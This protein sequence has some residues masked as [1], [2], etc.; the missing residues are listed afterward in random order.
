MLFRIASAA[1]LGIDAY[2]VEVEV[3]VSFGLPQFVIVGLP[4]AAVRESKERVQAA[5][6]NCGYEGQPSKIVVN[7]A[8]ANR[9]KEGSS[10]DLPIA[11]GLLAAS[12]HKGLLGPQGTGC[13]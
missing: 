10:F 9:R 13:A 1:L 12:G 7:L 6:K 2:P 8:P 5:L 4:D 11:L 3:D